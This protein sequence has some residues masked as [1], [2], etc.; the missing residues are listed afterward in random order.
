MPKLIKFMAASQET[1][2]KVDPPKPARAGVPEWYKKAN[3]FISG[4]MQITPEGVV[5]KD[6]KLCVP[7]LDAMTGG[8][9][10]EL[11]ADLLIE[12]TQNGVSFYW[13][14][15]PQL[16]EF[17][18]KEMAT[19]LP[20]PAGHDHDLYAWVIHWATIL[21][22]GY[23]ALVVHPLN[24]FDLPFITT[25]GI[26]DADNY[27][28]GGQIPFF[29]RSDFVGIIPAGTPIV[30]II[31]FKREDWK[32]EILPYDAKW[33]KSTMYSVSRFIT[34]GYKKLKWQKKHFE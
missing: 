31:P 17:R 25:N 33:M 14:E 1:D 16:I 29:L 18:N 21:P 10:I 11:P 34:G 32:H 6:I 24:R 2:D 12:R 19:T 5:N 30:Q 23:S 8:Y 13:H 9:L 26:V 4:K 15:E 28:T 20:R 22:P 27:F 7:F 3:R